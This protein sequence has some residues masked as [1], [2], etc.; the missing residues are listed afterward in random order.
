MYA[1]R[2]IVFVVAAMGLAAVP[3]ASMAQNSISSV[4]VPP[5]GQPGLDMMIL[6]EDAMPQEPELAEA[7]PEVEDVSW[8]G[9]S[10]D[11]VRPMHHLYTDYRRQLAR[12]QRNWSNLPQ[13]R[14]PIEGA[15]LTLGSIDPRVTILRE[16]LGLHRGGGFDEAVKAKLIEFQ[17]AHGL[18][19]DGVAGAGTLRAL[20]RGAAYY[21]RLM[22]LSMERVRRL[23]AEGSRYILVDAGSAQLWM[24]ENGRPVD[25]MKVIVGTP[26]SQTPMMAA[27]VRYASVNPY[28]NIPTDLVT[29]LIA[30]RVLNEGPAYLQARGY[31]VLD[32][33]GAESRVID[34]TTVDWQAVADGRQQLPVRQLP[35]AGNS[36]G[37]IKFMMPNEFG[38]YLHDTPNKALFQ[39]EN[40]WL[41]NGCVRVEDARR[42]ARW[43]F[44]EMPNPADFGPD[45]RVELEKPVPVYIT[46]LTAGAQLS[47]WSFQDDPYDRNAPILARFDSVGDGMRDAE[48]LELTS[49]TVAPIRASTSAG[50]A[51]SANARGQAKAV[52]GRLPSTVGVVGV[53]LPGVRE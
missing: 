49:P 18:T 23:P 4:W 13:V 41:S 16:R 22:L 11:L 25:S 45:A 24:Y 15:A 12:Y 28:W 33:W 2:G 19:A 43:I 42:L 30:P 6:E 21:E 17:Q 46:Y 20:N 37:E 14:V 34:P 51:K 50:L 38:I 52:P 26:Q 36:M 7:P 40:R 29:K 27:M 53:A 9:A 1:I 44:G 8:S 31:E 32:N 3:A 39:E 5:G 35:G 10:I 48:R 47:N